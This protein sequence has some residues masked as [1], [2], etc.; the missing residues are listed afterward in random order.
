MRKYST[1]LM[2]IAA[3]LPLLSACGGGGGSGGG[4]EASAATTVASLTAAG[5]S[6]IT[7]NV[8][9]GRAVSLP[10]SLE[11]TWDETEQCT[12]L[13][14]PPPKVVYSETVTCP[15]NGKPDCL[16][17]VPFFACSDNPAQTCGAIGRFLPECNA[18]ELPDRY[19]GGAAHEMIH[20]VL[21]AN[22]RQDW[23][24]HAAPEFVCQ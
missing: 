10:Q 4:G 18:I 11:A 7:S 6:E 8:D 21:R 14:A 13:S 5:A 22:G 3:S 20:Y 23:A 17:S 12:V 2:I 15:R 19:A 9:C 16:G 24:N 1:T